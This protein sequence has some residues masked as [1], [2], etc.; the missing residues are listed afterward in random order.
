MAKSYAAKGTLLK[1]GDGG[2][3]T[4][5]F[6]S[7]ANVGDITGP[8][9]ALDTVDVTH[10][11]SASKEF[12][13]T[14]LDGGE[15][16]LS[17]NYDPAETTH[18]NAAGGLIYAMEQKL[19]KNWQIVLTDDA[20]STIAFAAFVVGFEPEAPVAGKLAAK[21]KFRISGAVTLP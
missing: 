8:G 11:G 21:V 18:K 20:H 10:H 15:I 14:L 7:I 17:I 13:A 1:I 19:L 6:T 9:A 3:P 4:E 2:T 12:V 5:N 16:S